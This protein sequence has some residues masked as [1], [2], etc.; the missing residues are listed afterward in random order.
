[1]WTLAIVAGLVGALVASGIGSATGE[2]SHHTTVM[3]PTQYVFQTPNV[4]PTAV[5]AQ[6]N[7]PSIY[8]TLSASLVT[9]TANGDNGEV[10]TAGVLWQSQGPDVYILT[11]EDALDGAGTV[12]VTFSGGPS[13]TGRSI[14]GDEQTGVAVVEVNDANRPTAR[15]GHLTDLQIGESITTIGPE[16]PSVGG[17]GPLITGTVSGL[18]REVQTTDGPTM[19]GMIGISSSTP[20]PSGAAVVDPQGDVVGLTTSIQSIDDNSAVGATFAVPID[21]AVQ[22]AQQLLEGH[23]ATHP[24]LGVVE[25][26]TVLPSD[27]DPAGVQAGARVDSVMSSSPAAKAG[28]RVGDVITSLDGSAITS[29]ASLLLTTYGCPVYRPVTIRFLQGQTSAKA[30]ITPGQQPSYITPSS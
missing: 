20:P 25:A 22:V 1:M 9:I 30:T 17:V 10:S 12:R 2:F 8:N 11:S 18:D 19:L 16:G 4:Q 24:W 27:A 14:G 26:E 13:V 7:W 23:G 28:I 21:I 15:L 6:P 3:R 29:A 5:V